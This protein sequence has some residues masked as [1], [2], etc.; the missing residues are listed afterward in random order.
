VVV[1]DPVSCLA[2]RIIPFLYHPCSSMKT[3]NQISSLN[4]NIS[5]PHL[6][7]FL[8]LYFVMVQ[9]FQNIKSQLLRLPRRPGN[10]CSSP[11]IHTRSHYK[12]TKATKRPT[13]KAPTDPVVAVAP[14]VAGAEVAGGAVSDVVGVSEE[15]LVLTKEELGTETVL[16]AGTG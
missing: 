6:H 8:V 7:S 9:T 13:T 14:P 15:T 5:L 11:I 4:Q 16:L 1:V 12:Q 3:I 2:G 10:A